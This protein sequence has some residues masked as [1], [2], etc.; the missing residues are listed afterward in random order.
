LQSAFSQRPSSPSASPR[1]A[2]EFGQSRL[3]TEMQVANS[4]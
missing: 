3:R 2:Q 1:P 4:Q